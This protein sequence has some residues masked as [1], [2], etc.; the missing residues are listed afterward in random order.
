[1]DGLC[2]LGF[3][4]FADRRRLKHLCASENRRNRAVQ[5]MDHAPQQFAERRQF[6]DVPEV[7]MKKVLL[8]TRFFFH[9]FDVVNDPGK[10][11]MTV[12]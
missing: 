7:A 12:Q 6:L 5:F 2:L 1:M 10:I 9:V 11:V 8:D 3:G 4:F